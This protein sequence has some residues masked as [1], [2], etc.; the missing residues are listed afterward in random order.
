[1][2]LSYI[3]V[4]TPD[5]RA[6]FLWHLSNVKTMMNGLQFKVLRKHIF[7]QHTITKLF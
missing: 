6:F 3:V 1:M 2:V 5:S 4:L 7:M